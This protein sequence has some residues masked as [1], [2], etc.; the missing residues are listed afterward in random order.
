MLF[1][2]AMCVMTYLTVLALEFAPVVLEHPAFGHPAFRAALKFLKKAA[3]PLVIAGIVLSTLHQSSLGSLFLIIPHRLHPLWYSPILYVLFF[4]S[5]AGL[6]MMMVTLESILSAFFLGHAVRRDLLPGLGLAAAVVLGLYAAL[7]VGDLAARGVLASAL[8]GSGLSVLFV[9]EIA[10]CSLVPAALLAFRRVRSSTAGLAAC[11]VTA[12][13]GMVLNRI[14]T[15]IAAVSRPE[16]MPYF[17][18]WMEIAVSLGVVSAAALAFLFLVE[19]LRVYEEK[20]GHAPPGP[21]AEPSTVENLAPAELAAPRRYSL[22]FILAAA[23]AVALLPEGAVLGARPERTPVRAA[24]AVDGSRGAD[25]KESVGKLRLPLPGE[26]APKEAKPLPLLLIDGNRDGRSVLFAHGRHAELLGGEASCAECHHLGLPLDHNPSCAE[27]HR[28]MYEAT[29]VF[30]HSAHARALGGN[31]GCAQC[32][33]DPAAAKTRETAMACG[34]CHAE[35]AAA[36]SFVKAPGPRWREAAGYM[37]AMHG[38]CAACHEK[39]AKEEPVAH[40]ANFARC[41]ACHDA[42]LSEQLRRLAPRAKVAKG[43][44]ARPGGPD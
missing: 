44:G 15:C 11:S 28:D 4:V 24:R 41:D 14:D 12:V 2:V 1:E 21:R 9:F 32:H 38:L 19:R 23:A 29:D 37:D 33:V 8:D 25:S 42:D 17:P 20:G 27:C 6:G 34:A 30:A 36:G 7:R 35:L 18:S 3:V 26:A 10:A 5:A 43:R 39:K 16:G 31:A 40:P 22:A 13:A